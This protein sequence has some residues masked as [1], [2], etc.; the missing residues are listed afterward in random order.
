MESDL[1]RS[2]LSVCDL[3]NRSEVRYM[4]VGGTAVALHGYYRHS[5]GPSGKLTTKPDIDLWFDPTY[6]NYFK[7]LTVLEELGTDVSR[8]RSETHPDPLHS[9]FKLDMEEFTLDALP[10]IKA[11]IPFG[12][13]YSRRDEVAVEGIDIPYIGYD[14][15]IE[16]KKSSDREKDKNDIQNL[17]R[18][19]GEE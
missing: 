2:V 9:F 6:D 17:R 7:L 1:K 16:D 10:S 11:A 19:R 18:E 14:D 13:A 8:S 5:M 3:L 15:L 12:E 4:L